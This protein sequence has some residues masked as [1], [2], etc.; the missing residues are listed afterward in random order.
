MLVSKQMHLHWEILK[1]LAIISLAVATA[2]ILSTQLASAADR[3]PNTAP[4]LLP[5]EMSHS[6]T[7]II[8][9][10]VVPLKPV[11]EDVA[12][13]V[14]QTLEAHRQSNWELAVVMWAG[15]TLP[16][17]NQVWRHIGAAQAHLRM[18]QLDAAAAELELARGIHPE[19]A[20]VRYFTALLRLEESAL[21]DDWYD[22]Q[23]SQDVVFVSHMPVVPNSR[24]MFKLAAINELKAA[25]AHAQDIHEDTPLVSVDSPTEAALLPTVGDLL[26]ATGSTCFDGKAHNMLSALHLEYGQA[27]AAEEHLDAAHHAGITIIFGYTDL[28]E[29][30]QAVGR[31]SDATRAFAKAIARQPGAAKSTIRALENVRDALREIW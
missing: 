19:N 6:A 14:W 25:I 26:S 13:N 1:W 15:V 24:S 31:H 28:G 30:Y 2:I 18:A 10:S 8:R 20:L 16:G 7:P 12:M 22:P 27:A 17:E 11:T 4:A 21:A 9:Q 29:H 3:S 5:M 23:V